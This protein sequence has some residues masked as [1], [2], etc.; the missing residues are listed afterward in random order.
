MNEKNI[1]RMTLLRQISE[2]EFMMIDLGLFLNTHPKCQDALDAYKKHKAAYKELV[3]L[4]NCE[5]G[6]L[7][8]YQVNNTNCWDW[9]NT[10]WPWE[11]EGC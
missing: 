5:C 9:V 7:T 8:L 1:N 2:H 4:Y 10:P 11:M 6:P 3:E